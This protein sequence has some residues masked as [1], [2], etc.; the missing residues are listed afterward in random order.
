MYVEELNLDSLG[1]IFSLWQWVGEGVYN[2]KR[3]M[4]GLVYETTMFGML[5]LKIYACDQLPLLCSFQF[6]SKYSFLNIDIPNFLF[7]YV[8]AMYELII[9]R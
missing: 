7:S 8:I 5:T 2:C 4:G 3:R 1:L 6:Y 9:M